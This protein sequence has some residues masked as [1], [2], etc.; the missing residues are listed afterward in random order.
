M[1]L[2]TP[3]SGKLDKV[4][5]D[6]PYLMPR[7]RETTNDML[8]AISVREMVKLK[9]DYFGTPDWDRMRDTILAH[10][11]L[12]LESATQ[13]AFDD[14]KNKVIQ[15]VNTIMPNRVHQHEGTVFEDIRNQGILLPI[16]AGNWRA[17]DIH[18]G[19][20]L[21]Y[22]ANND[23]DITRVFRS[24]VLLKNNGHII[25][26]Q[27]SN[28]RTYSKC[29]E[30]SMKNKVGTNMVK[31]YDLAQRW[32][33]RRAVCINCIEF[34]LNEYN[35]RDD[36][37]RRDKFWVGFDGSEQ[38]I[39]SKNDTS[40]L[41]TWDESRLTGPDSFVTPEYR[42][43]FRKLAAFGEDA[44][45]YISVFDALDLPSWSYNFDTSTHSLNWRFPIFLTR[46][47]EESYKS[48]SMGY[49]HQTSNWHSETGPYLGAEFECFVRNDREDMR[50][51]MLV[52]RTAIQMFHPTEYPESYTQ[53][54]EHQLLYAKDDGSLDEGDG[55]EYVS[56]PLSYNYWMNA[57]PDRFWEYFRNNFRAMNSS[58]CGIHVHLGW[59]SMDVIHRYIF[60]YFLNRMN[61]ENSELLQR[62][63]GRSGTY[64][65]IWN[66]LVYNGSKD[67]VFQ[68]A[69]MKT[70]T[71]SNPK[72]NSINT[73]HDD[74]IELRYFQGNTGENSIKG[75]LQFVNVLYR[76]SERVAMQFRDWDY[77]NEERPS[78]LVDFLHL[79]DTNVDSIFIT[80]MFQIMDDDDIKYLVYKMG[81][82]WVR[83]NYSIRESLERISL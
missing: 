32:T 11:G 71:G 70:Q 40:H 45:H 35:H 16:V 31:V 24:P 25:T 12:E 69:L 26:E 75:I 54:G 18:V 21:G 80:R 22:L 39:I 46:A 42:R 55:I 15:V 43:F 23:E 10:R 81:T 28:A 36:L 72:Y 9:V 8:L 65:S 74:T 58:Q 48:E 66:S 5:E 44:I 51:N 67:Q 79:L 34:A 30:C 14:V 52:K 4:Y 13:N 63:A 61:V 37:H 57:V 7:D 78:A 6:D 50:S 60:L 29:M 76:I 20:R 1:R 2:I 33:G 53:D 73:R 77:M 49:G 83:D 38:I 56:Q 47:R 41:E 59:D 64:Y 62:V 68:V 27:E 3:S 19:Y 17:F 82:E